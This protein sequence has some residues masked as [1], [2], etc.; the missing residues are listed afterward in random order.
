MKLNQIAS[1]AANL[2][3]VRGCRTVKVMGRRS[4]GKAAGQR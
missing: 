4:L 1:A 2:P 3:H